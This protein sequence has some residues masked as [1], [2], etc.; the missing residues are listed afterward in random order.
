[1]G[2]R[3]LGRR[4]KQ[5]REDVGGVAVREI[6]PGYW[7]VDFQRDGKRYRK[8]GFATLDAAK[9]HAGAMRDHVVKRGVEVLDLS[10]RLREDALEAARLLEGTGVGILAAV[11]DYLVRH[12]PAGGE[13]V[14]QTCDKYLVAMRAA[15]RRPLSIYDKELKFDALREAHG[16]TPTAALDDAAIEQWAKARGVG[17]ATERKYI[18]AA[19]HLLAFFQ[20]GGRLRVEATRDET[21]PVTWDVETVR[22][23]MATAETVAPE[24]VPAFAILF[25]AGVRPHEVARLTWE[26]VDLASGI[27][28]LTGDMTKTHS[29]RNVEIAGNLR[30]WLQRYKGAGKVAPNK[31]QYRFRQEKVVEAA[32]LDGWPVDVARHT[33]ATMHYGA[34]Q[35][36]AATMAQ[37]GHFGNPTTFLRHYKGVPVTAADAAAYWKIMPAKTKAAKTVIPFAAAS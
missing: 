3:H 31:T 20:R 6:R 33:F 26:Q 36:A 37:L 29:M 12:P 28:R 27:I 19:H 8:A 17:I 23:I 18:M 5:A 35:N 15:K 21:P 1:M 2:R 4:R 34:H 22:K 32:G 25:F 16:T 9:A 11:H 24:I 14:A 30:A 7:Q 13:T 10:P